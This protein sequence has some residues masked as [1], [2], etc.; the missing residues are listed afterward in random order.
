MA[1][2]TSGPCRTCADVGDD[3]LFML[4]DRR[5]NCFRRASREFVSGLEKVM[6]AM[7]ASRNADSVRAL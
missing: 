2:K 5:K 3:G 7:L 6:R 4:T 1:C